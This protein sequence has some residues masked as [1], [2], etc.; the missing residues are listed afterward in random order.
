MEIVKPG[1]KIEDLVAKT[2]ASVTDH[3]EIQTEGETSKKILASDLVSGGGAGGGEANTAS[4]VG[5]GGVG[6]YKQ[7]VGVDIELKKINA[8]STKVTVTDD[9]ANS[10]VDIDVAPESFSQFKGLAEVKLEYVSVSQIQIEGLEGTSENIY[11]NG[12][13]LDCST[14]K[15]IDYDDNLLAA[16]GTDSG[17]AATDAVLYYVYASNASASYRA[18]GIGL[19]ATAHTGGYL[20][21]AGN[22]L[23][24]RLIGWVYLIDNAGTAEFRDSDTERLVISKWNPRKIM[25]YNTEGT[26]HTYT[27]TSWRYYYNT[28]ASTQ[29]KFITHEDHLN[30]DL[31]NWAYFYL[32][33]NYCYTGIGIDGVSP[34]SGTLLRFKTTDA[35]FINFGAKVLSA[36]TAGY[37]YAA[38][39]Q[40]GAASSGSYR[41]AVITIGIMG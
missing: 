32:A 12:E 24:W 41:N 19:S 36:T 30:I 13:F 4:N 20:A 10:E 17:G 25:G 18:S 23:N 16:D 21:A 7:K 27:T 35:T 28:L 8:G 1:K 37:H 14:P 22:G 2:A 11:I 6:I 34:I 5:T 39:L 33:N 40:M 9:A 15:T 31:S 38:I 3:L 29:I 26:D